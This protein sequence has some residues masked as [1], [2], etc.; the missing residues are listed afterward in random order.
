M[1]RFVNILT[2][3]FLTL[4]LHAQDYKPLSEAEI[5]ELAEKSLKV[6]NIPGI[7]VAV[8]KDNEVVH[9]K[10]MPRNSAHPPRV[11]D[12]IEHCGKRLSSLKVPQSVTFVDFIEQ[13]L[14][15]KVPRR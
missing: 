9:A 15:G 12:L 13:T 1:V 2:L 3:F 8:I 10:I 5:D 11:E 4:S 7:A 6:F 14:S